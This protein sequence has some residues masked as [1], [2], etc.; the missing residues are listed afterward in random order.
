MFDDSRSEELLRAAQQTSGEWLLAMRMSLLLLL[1]SGALCCVESI[2]KDSEGIPGWKDRLERLRVY[3]DEL[4][5]TVD[6]QLELAKV[7]L[8]HWCGVV[9]VAVT[10]LPP[11]C[12]RMSRQRLRMPSVPGSGQC[13]MT[14]RR[15]SSRQ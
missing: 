2:E 9:G 1:T 7:Q 11:A 14:S 15:R 6:A 4:K 13:W 10:Q 12:Y 5:K 3:H 8:G